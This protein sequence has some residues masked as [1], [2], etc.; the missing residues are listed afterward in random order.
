MT[1]KEG[2]KEYTKSVKVCF[3]KPYY[4]FFTLTGGHTFMWDHC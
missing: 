4:Q 1:K 3:L 2:N